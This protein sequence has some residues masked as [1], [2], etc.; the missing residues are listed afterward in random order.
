MK[1]FTVILLWPDY[2]TD[3]FGTDTYMTCVEA[4]DVEH[5]IVK[6]QNEAMAGQV[7]VTDPDDLA[8]IAVIAVIA[9]ERQDVAPR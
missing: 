8:V 6:A 3:S 7:S 1:K 5:A 2:A 9:G 4:E